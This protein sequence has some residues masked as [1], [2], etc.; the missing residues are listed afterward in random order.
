MPTNPKLPK[1]MGTVSL[2]QSTA[3]LLILPSLGRDLNVDFCIVGGGIAG[4]STAYEL[5]IQVPT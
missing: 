1:D 3:P 4:L 2:W 5:V